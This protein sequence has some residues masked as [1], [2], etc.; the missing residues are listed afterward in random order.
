MSPMNT[1]ANVLNK[2][3]VNSIQWYI[4]KLL[5]VTRWHLSPGRKTGSTLGKHSV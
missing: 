2:I 1:D 3:R 5:T 4:E